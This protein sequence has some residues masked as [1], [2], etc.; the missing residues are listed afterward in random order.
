ML[1]FYREG[2]SATVKDRR[3]R[4]IY[5]GLR[6]RAQHLAADQEEQI[7]FPHGQGSHIRL[8]HLHCGDDGVMVGYILVGDQGLH[9]REEIGAA[10]KG[11]HLRRQMEDTGSRLRHVGGQ[12]PAV[13][14]GIGQQLLF[15]QALGVVQGLL[16]RVAKHPVC[17]PLQSRQVVEFRGLFFFLFTGSGGADR[18]VPR[19]RRL[20][21][22]GVLRGNDLLRNG[23]GPANRQAYMMVFLLLKLVIFQSRSASM[24]RVGVW[25]RPTFRVRW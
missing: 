18:R 11:W 24:A 8:F 10:V 20:Y 14:P 15:I 9:I 13:R 1:S 23:L 6:R 25:T 22:L 17:L 2:I 21:G 7:A 12:V 19:A 16:C 4:L 3:D 5:M